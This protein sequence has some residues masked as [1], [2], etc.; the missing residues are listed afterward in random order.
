M[1]RRI[2]SGVL[3]GLAAVTLAVGG[4]TYSA[5]VVSSD[6]APNIVG[7]GVLHLDLS[8]GSAH[9]GL[10]FDNLMPGE[11]S[12]RLFWLASN[13]ALSVT[14]ATLAVTFHDLV[15]V[16]A[17]C[18]V[19]TGKALGEQESGV[20]GCTIAGA[21]VTGTPRQ[22]NL[23][24]LLAVDVEYGDSSAGSPGCALVADGVSLLEDV[25]P[26]NLRSSALRDRTLLLHNGSDPLVLAP[27]RGLCLAVTAHWLPGVSSTAEASPQHPT[28]NAA[29][30]DSFTVD[31]RFDLA[32]VTR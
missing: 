18:D 2:V 5:P 6:V 14:P 15:D 10:A 21:Q 8:G 32:Q 17:P 12:R 1:N 30:G 20:G 3:A 13:D 11:A 31:V 27:G 9:A 19:S 26:G 24:R 16:A 22:G 23:S 7:V 25:S 4:A 29:Q 28:D